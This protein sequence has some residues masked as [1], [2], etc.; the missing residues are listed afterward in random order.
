MAYGVVIDV[1]APVEVYDA[2]H[3]AVLES[4]QSTM[5]G[6]LLHVGRETGTGFQV[7]EV[8]TDRAQFDRYNEQ[9]VWPAAAR[10]EQGGMSVPQPSRTDE[11]EVRGLVLPG[12]RL[13]Q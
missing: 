7:I 8:W 2:L 12:I 5:D 9:V 6:L 10:L 4:T 13:V 1:D 3:A 11:F